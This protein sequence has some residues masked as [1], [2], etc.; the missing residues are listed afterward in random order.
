MADNLSV[1][2]KYIRQDETC[3]FAAEVKELVNGKPRSKVFGIVTSKTAPDEWA[4]FVF[5]KRFGAWSFDLDHILPIYPET[6]VIPHDLRF[7][8]SFMSKGDILPYSHHYEAPSAESANII[9]QELIKVTSATKLK[10]EPFVW[11][12]NYNTTEGA[13]DEASFVPTSAPATNVNSAAFTYTPFGYEK[14]SKDDRL[15]VVMSREI[16]PEFGTNQFVYDNA[17][18][19]DIN[20]TWVASQL[21]SREAEFTKLLGIT[22]CLATWNV[23]GKKPSESLEPWLRDPTLQHDIYAVGFQELDLTAEA[24]LLGDTTRAAPWEQQ[25]M[26]TLSLQGEYVRIMT[27]QLV[28]VLLCVYVKKEHVPHV[29]DVQSGLAGVG[30]MGMMGNKGGV[31]IRFNLYDSTICIVNS[32]LNAHF[33]N[34]A[35]RNQDMKDIARRIIFYNDDSSM[36]SIYEHDML[37]WIGDLNYRIALSDNEVKEKIKRREW[38]ALFH[39]DQL[40]QQMKSGSAF[41]GFQESPIQF[42][43]TYKYDIGTNVYDS[44]EKKRTPAWCDRVLWRSGKTGKNV[45]NIFQLAYRRHEMLSSD[46]RPVS[47]SFQLKVKSIVP[48]KRSRLY[49][50]L[51]KELDKKENE[52]MPDAVLS[53]N[54]VVFSDVRYLVP[55]SQSIVIENTGQVV[56]RFRFIPK[57]DERKF[58]KPWLWVSPPFGVITPKEKMTVNLTIHVDNGT[59]HTLNNGRESLEDILILHL[60]NGKDYFVTVS[61][62]FLV[63]SFGNTLDFLVRTPNP[64]RANSPLFPNPTLS[65]SPASRTAPAT[66]Q[67]PASA[68][69]AEQKLSVPKELWR[70]VDY[71]YKKGMLEEGLFLQSGVQKEMEIIRECLDT[72]E[73]FSAHNVSVHSMAETIIRFLESLTEPVIPFS[74]Y[75]AALDASAQYANCR[76]LVS[77]LPLAHYNVFYYLIAFLREALAHRENKLA[78]EKLAVIF[79]SVMIRPSPEQASSEAIIKKKA[80][81]I[82]YFLVDNDDLKLN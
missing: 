43:P 72:G 74:H 24:L 53:S 67:T 41:E 28:G 79:A 20:S 32:H 82:Y 35:R 15:S 68:S 3:R 51:V 61:G 38:T 6:K 58:C 29:S 71:I 4:V 25:I 59:V 21:K 69:D 70:L 54:N 22:I 12:K 18:F 44:S 40:Y 60:E 63:S 78:P 13:E 34:V 5:K 37:F 75:Q 14:P 10:K 31:A 52:C 26:T 48:E 46:H 45:D 50:E 66:P 33:E 39:A 76:T 65:P 17:K 47:A 36:Y 2:Q 73:S 49:Q 81:F 1:V 23:N 19:K 30:M 64:V 9:V 27:K 42:A 57:L 56:A 8:I 62:K 55:S 77:Q 7:E 11:L 80:D 16:S